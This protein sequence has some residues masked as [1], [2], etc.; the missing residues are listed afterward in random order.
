M[1]ICIDAGHGGLDSGAV[2]GKQKEKDYALAVAKKIANK[3]NALNY[4]VVMTRETDIALMLQKRCD[5]G[6]LCDLFVSVHLNS[7]ENKN[8]NGIETFFW[9]DKDKKLATN[10]QNSLV[11]LFPNEKNRGVKKE[12]FYVLKNTKVPA[13]LVELGFLS[14]DQT[15]EKFN[16]FS[17]QDKLANAVVNG[18]LQ[19]M[20]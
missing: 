1:K 11:K 7:A 17:Y 4:D 10:I 6:N 20:V 8:A 13:A 14:H 16:S 2:N 5:I 19:T 12:Q 3:L 18:I 9:K 15:A